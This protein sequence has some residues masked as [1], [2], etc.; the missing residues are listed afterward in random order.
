[1]RQ[2]KDI[3]GLCINWLDYY[4]DN[5]TISDEP[6]FIIHAC[7]VLVKHGRKSAMKKQKGSLKRGSKSQ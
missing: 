5:I 7:N 2:P 3:P 1:M 4:E 6:D